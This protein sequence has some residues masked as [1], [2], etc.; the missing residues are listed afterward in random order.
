MLLLVLL[1]RGRH[2]NSLRHE[3]LKL[4]KFERT[5]VQRTRQTEA[6]IHQIFFARTIPVIHAP[7]LAHG[8]VG[9]VDKHQ[10]I[11][12]HVVNK[13]RRRLTRLAS[14]H[15]PR[16][17]LDAFAKTNLAHHFQI[18]ARALLDALRFQ[19]FHLTDKLIF[20]LVQ[21]GFDEVNRAQHIRARAGV[22]RAGEHREATNFLLDVPGE[23]IEQ[24]QHFDLVVKERDA[25]RSLRMFSRKNVEHFAAHAKSPTR[26]IHIVTVVLHLGQSTDCGALIELVALAQM[27]NH[28]VIIHRVADTVNARHRGHDDAVLP[29]HDALGGRQTHLLDV[30]VNRAVLLD[31]QVARRHIG[32]GL[33][34]VVIRNEILH[35]IVRK[36]LAKLAIKLRRQRLVR[37]HH[38]GW[39]PRPRD[40][41][42]HRERLAGAGYA[43]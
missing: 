16:V 35:R 34:V 42:S 1:W 26:K 40:N 4:F 43:Q 27:Q 7:N 21:L 2:K 30:L 5:V 25:H 32:L 28:R 6:V 19:Q 23:R 13:R 33:V 3:L 29:L 31:E 11:A 39:P 15:V 12:R 41:V 24:L 36:E 20:A 18:K 22:M 10:R 14:A 17:V 37:C 38:N 9:L 8:H